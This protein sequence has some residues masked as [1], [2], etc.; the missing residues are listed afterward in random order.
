[1]FSLTSIISIIALV[2]GLTL[3]YKKINLSYIW[4][5]Y[6]HFVYTLF[7]LVIAYFAITESIYYFEKQY[8]NETGIPN[9][10]LELSS[11]EFHKWILILIL[12]GLEKDVFPLS[13]PGEFLAAIAIYLGW[14]ALGISI[15]FEYLL[16]LKIKKRMEGKRSIKHEGHYV[17]C[18]WNLRTPEFITNTIGA[19][20]DFSNKKCR[21]V[22][23]ND[24]LSEILELNPTLKE[25]IETEKVDYIKGKT[26]DTITLEQA[27]IHMAASIILFADGLGV[28]ADERTLLRAL[29]I[30]RFCRSKNG[31]KEDA[32]YMIAEVNDKQF[33]PSLLASDVNEV[34]C[35]TEIGNNIITQSIITRGLTTVISDLLSFGD[36]SNEFY[37]INLLT[38][39][40]LVGYTYD[41][42]IPILR[43]YDIQLIGIKSVFYADE[44][45]DCT[46]EEY[47][48]LET[49][50]RKFEIKDNTKLYK[51]K[52]EHPKIEIIDSEI[53]KQRLKNE[54]DGLDTQLIVNPRKQYEKEYNYKADD[55]DQ[56]I[57]ICANG[58]MI[59]DIPFAENYF[60]NR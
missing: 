50:E 32:I 60:R 27:N 42:L 2:I 57:V 44:W 17:I 21:I 34:I 49:E 18:G 52:N 51:K 26:R 3:Y 48:R 7:I 14:I 41:E 45:I 4:R 55:D 24:D 5:R 47:N 12:A 10:L 20:T 6:K 13:A 40:S 29:A 28:D 37:S 38:H 31:G 58:K 35:T 53:I 33:E 11:E 46:E 54:K 36:K 23:I 25:L 1:M 30:S 9:P 39:K 8:T 56:L 16:N 15:L 59:D 19:I 22:I 43:E